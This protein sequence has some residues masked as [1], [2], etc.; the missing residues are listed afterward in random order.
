[1]KMIGIILHTTQYVYILGSILNSIWY[2]ERIQN[3]ARLNGSKTKTS[4]TMLTS[5]W[6]L[7]LCSKVANLNGKNQSG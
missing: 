3:S 6:H 7:C 5:W 2:I 1:M 4:S